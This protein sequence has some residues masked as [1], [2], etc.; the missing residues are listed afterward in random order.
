MAANRMLVLLLT[1]ALAPLGEAQSVGKTV[2]KRRVA[3]TPAVSRLVVEAEA[4][5][6]KS[7][8]ATAE[9]KLQ[10]ATKENAGDYRAWFDLGFVYGATGKK[11]EAIEAYRK[12]VAAKA[13]VFEANLNLGILLAEVSPAEAEKFLHAATQLKPSEKPEQGQYRAWLSLGRV[14]EARD[15]AQALA[16]YLEAAK[17][18]PKEAEPH[19]SAAALLEK[20]GRLDEAAR[21]FQQAAE[22]DP[23][24]VEALA[25]L[26]NVYTRAKRLPEAET[27]LRMYLARNPQ[28][29]DAH[30][31]LG[32]VLLALGRAD[33]G[34]A[35][36]ES[37]LK[38]AP[39]D[40]A[41]ER[42]VAGLEMAAGKYEEAAERY[43]RLAQRAPQD[44]GL[45]HAL[46]TALL[47]ARRFAE[48]Q[49]ELLAALKLKPDLAEAYGDL[50]AAASENK[51]YPLVIQ[52]LDARARY[53]PESAGTY[54]LRATAY[55]HLR[56][57]PQASENYKRFLAAAAG[58]YPDQEWQ[59]RHRLIAIDP[60]S[61]DK[62]R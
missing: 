57:F 8:F 16:A 46:G 26:V 52:A 60:E 50:A 14:L 32:R 1:L 40:Q 48:A 43:H 17:R 25:G 49:R 29:A 12:S 39:G 28:S 47:R 21:E 30:L 24:S 62:R 6:E 59:A 33:E 38:L 55:D 54:F 2:R 34:R 15:A 56:A 53:L 4:A 19:F 44:A 3:E 58:K 35:E 7:D 11:A 45:R 13:D 18:Q 9:T 31:Q 41:A 10:Q 61:R 22:R 42:E 20:E 36:L 51:E 23:A 5:M 27:A 37:A